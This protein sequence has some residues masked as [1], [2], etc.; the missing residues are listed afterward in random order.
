[1]D[2]LPDLLFDKSLNIWYSCM[3]WLIVY[4]YNTISFKNK[5]DKKE[6]LLWCKKGKDL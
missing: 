1:M 4:T 2:F 5:Y 3:L 6:L